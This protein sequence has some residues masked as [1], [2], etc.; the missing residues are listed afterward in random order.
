MKTPYSILIFLCLLS[1][2][3]LQAQSLDAARNAFEMGNA[4]YKNGDYETALE[5]Y[6][7]ADS[8]AAGDAIE[9]N[10]G[11]TYYKLDKLPE[12]ILHY[13]R[14]LK[15]NPANEAALHNLRLAN[16]KIADRIKT[17][18]KSRLNLWWSEFRYGLGPDGWAWV[19]VLMAVISVVLLICYFLPLGRNLR[20][21]G[22]FAGIIFIALT[23]AA[24]SLA[25]SAKTHLDTQHSAIIF[26]DKVDVKSEPRDQ[27]TNVFVL[28]AGTKVKLLNADA[29]WYEIKIASGNQG[30]I[31]KS[32]L[33]A[34]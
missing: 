27:S 9:Y 12:S 33:E 19:S 10:L 31:K 21:F 32:D 2:L 14:A 20:R 11:N 17:L 13:E 8:N 29:G 24:F 4:A 22:F 23:V 25:R 15:Y 16:S 7:D 26:A 30:W 34:I 5:Y 3:T 18:P 1:G 6:L 28:H